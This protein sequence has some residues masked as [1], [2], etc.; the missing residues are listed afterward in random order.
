MLGCIDGKAH[1]LFLLV[2]PGPKPKRAS[3]SWDG[4]GSGAQRPLLTS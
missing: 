2:H 4:V 1:F 3:G